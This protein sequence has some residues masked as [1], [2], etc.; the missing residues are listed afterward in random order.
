MKNQPPRTYLALFFSQGI[1]KTSEDI[2]IP[3]VEFLQNL[4]G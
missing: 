2:V 4:T 3:K 1:C